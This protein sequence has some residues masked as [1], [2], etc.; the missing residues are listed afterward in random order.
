MYPACARDRCSPPS[1]TLRAANGSTIDAFGTRDID[2]CFPGLRTSHPFLL[3][4]VKRPILGADFFMCQELVIDI[5]RRRLFSDNTGVCVR[6]RPAAV[7]TDLCGLSRTASP[8]DITLQ[9]FP[10]VIATSLVYDSS[11]PA[12][13]GL[14][15][16]IPTDGPPVFARPRRL[17]GDK[18]VV[19]Q[20]EFQKMMEMGIIRR[21]DS[22]WALHLSLIHI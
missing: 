22:S 15:H 5:P 19:A 2:L 20:Q 14:Q 11:R 17:F 1:S 9:E 18:L 6:A 16:S 4:S 12:K 13:H 10:A 3:A 21:S 8:W 7:L